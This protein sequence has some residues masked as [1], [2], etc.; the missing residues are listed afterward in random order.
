MRVFITEDE[1]LI[2]MDLRELLE[3]A[4]HVV[5]GEATNGAQALDTLSEMSPDV[6][7]LMFL[8]ISMPVM[9]GLTLA[10]ELVKQAGEAGPQFPI[11]MLTAYSAPEQIM[12]ATEAGVYGYIVKPYNATDIL[13]AME[14]ARARFQQEVTL[15]SEA[16]SLTEKLE[17]RKLLDRAKAI[18]MS[19]GLSE[20]D[21]YASMQKYA[22]DKRKSLR[23]VA[24]A[25]IATDE[26]TS[27]K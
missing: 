23:Q 26:M 13:P 1:G 11:V 16:A 6:P 27:S 25:V 10:E 21:A 5:I 12:R 4:G 19:R 2:R 9:D 3:E 14:V 24:E 18:L 17:T 20:K 22:M 7:D 8:D 15:R